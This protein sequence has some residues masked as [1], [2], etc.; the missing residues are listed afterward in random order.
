VLSPLGLEG[1]GHAHPQV[2]GGPWKAVLLIA[3]E[4]IEYLQGLGYPVYPGALG[5]NITTV[6]IDFRRLR[7][8][9]RFRLG[10]AFI[11]LTRNRIPCSTLDVYNTGDK[12]IQHAI[13][14]KRVKAGDVASPRWGL[15]GFYARVLEAGL[16]RQGDIIALTDQTV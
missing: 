3:S 8:G 12:P 1:D 16:V 6:G 2:H 13:Y 11:E 14:D 7:L 4:D 5:E 9:Q 10:Q 15:S